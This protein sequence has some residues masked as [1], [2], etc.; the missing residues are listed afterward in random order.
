M[1]PHS[2]KRPF[3]RNAIL[4]RLSLPDLA[5]IGEFLEPIVLK[6]RMVLQEPKKR[7]EHVYFIE[8]GLISLRIVAAGSILETAVLGYRGAVG[9]SF[10]LGGHLPTHQS[11]VLFPGSALRIHVDNLS[12]VM[13]ERPPIRVQ[14]LRYVHALTLHCA[15][16]GFC[17]VWHDRERRLACWLCLTC[18][19][20]DGRVL[21]ITHHYLS[22]VMG[23]RRAGVTETLIRFEEHG[24]IRKMRGVLQIEERRRLEEAACGCYGIIAAAYASPPEHLSYV[25][26]PAG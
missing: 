25:E 23:L 24:L 3:V 13:N 17:G 6:E 1:L 10:L 8:A 26:Q 4:A 18:D 22:A 12:R 14:L 16:T 7:V 20:F 19:A 21:P 9:A 5:A 15:Q 2:N 11:V